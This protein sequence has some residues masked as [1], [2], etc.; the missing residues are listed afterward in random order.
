M[1]IGCLKAREIYKREKESGTL[2]N[3]AGKN[4]A[5]SIIILDSGTVIA[6]CLTVNKLMNLIEKSNSKASM[7]MNPS[8]SKRLT[9]YDCADEDP[10]P[11]LDSLLQEA[12]F[13][14]DVEDET[15]E[16]EQN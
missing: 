6:S 10:N 13:C 12:T 15:A 9:V 5:R 8:T 1:A 2:L 11:D 16:E 14:D 3:A 4:K 7:E